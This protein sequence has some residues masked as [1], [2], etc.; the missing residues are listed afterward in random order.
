MAGNLSLRTSQRR[1][2]ST[3]GG[4]FVREE[5]KERLRDG[6]TE[7]RRDRET[8]K[9]KVRGTGRKHCLSFS[10]SLGLSV[11]LLFQHSYIQARTHSRRAVDPIS[12]F[13]KI[14]FGGVVDV[15]E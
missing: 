7:G 14:G 9:R 13:L 10:P 12:G 11:F 5:K 6:E 8:E 4:Y 3:A 1:R 15:D 2:T